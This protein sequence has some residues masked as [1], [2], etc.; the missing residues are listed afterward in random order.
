MRTGRTW[1]QR[2]IIARQGGLAF[3][4]LRFSRTPEPR[5]GAGPSSAGLG[6]SVTNAT[7]PAPAGSAPAEKANRPF[8]ALVWVFVLVFVVA[9]GVQV[10]AQH[11]NA[12]RTILAAQAAGAALVAERVNTNLAA[13]MGAAS[14]SV[15]AM[16]GATAQALAETAAL[17]APAIAA[18][19]V[20]NGEGEIQA[21]TDPSWADLA[22]AAAGSAGEAPAWSG[23][24]DLGQLRTAPAIVR[25]SGE[26]A[27]VL[28]ID[29]A[30]LLPNPGED[31]RIMIATE[32]GAALYA[33]PALQRAGARAQRLVDK[34]RYRRRAH[35]RN[36]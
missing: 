33:S 1:G 10:K 23:A 3:V 24:P 29:P 34:T 30:S 16:R 6:N 4:R 7:F 21:I 28:V 17:A 9:V 13:S 26:R 35:W 27:L 12:V 36:Q 14:A 20:L 11:D 8:M 31:A 25:R 32:A 22:M 5:F 2:A 15:E 18:A 19:A